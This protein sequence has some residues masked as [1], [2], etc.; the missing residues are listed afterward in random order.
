MMRRRLYVGI[1]LILIV[2]IVC[3]IMAVDVFDVN[4]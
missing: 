4:L 3:M 2:S 1:S